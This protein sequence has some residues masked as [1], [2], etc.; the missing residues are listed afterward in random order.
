M[1]NPLIDDVLSSADI[2]DIISSKI[3]LKKAGSNFS[4]CCPFHNEKTPSFIV[5]P[6]KQIFKC[7]WC[8]K[9]GNV[10]TFIQEYEKIDFRDAVKELAKTENIDLSKYDVTVKKFAADSDEKWKLKRIHI[11]AQQ[12]FKSQ[13]ENSPEAQNYVKEKRKLSPQLIEQF[14]I[15]YAPDKHF[16]LI[17][18][19]RNKGFTDADILEASLAK[20]NATWEIYAFFR[21]R[22]T[23][24]IFDIMGNVVWFS[25]RVLNPEEKPKYINSAEHKAFEKSKILYGLNFA[26]NW[27]R[28]HD[29]IIIVEWQMDVLWLAKLGIPVWVATSWTSLTDDHVKILKRYTEN[30][31]LMFDNDSA[32]QQ[33][34][35]RA[36]KLFY[37]QNLFPKIINIP[38]P[39][40]DIDEISNEENGKTIFEE[41][42]TKAKD[43]FLVLYERIRASLDMSSPIDKQKLINTMFETIIAVDSVTIQE[44]YKW[45]LSEKLWLAYEILDT[46]FKKF[47]KTDWKFQIIQNTRRQEQQQLEKFQLERERLFAALFYQNLIDKYLWDSAKKQN[48]IKFVELLSKNDKDNM[49]AKVL[50]NTATTEEIEKLEELSL[51]RDKQLEEFSDIEIR[52]QHIIKTVLPYIQTI[53]QL[54]LKNPNVSAEVKGEILMLRKSL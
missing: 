10:L 34:T 22:I 21:N 17:Q 1:A 31:Y 40:K 47:K 27:I 32:W 39:R 42:L 6:T 38:Q 41:C 51:W 49:Y 53:L 48:F 25:A 19:L 9:G 29:K 7:F 8:W 44:H 14:W 20:K 4:W 54:C 50:N 46:Q 52:Y 11:L 45:L 3:P 15:G 43:G 23:F 37:Q 5:S 24:P 26:K 30:I 18:L 36:L 28:E 12:F 35:Q 33:A 2:V 13:F 16:E